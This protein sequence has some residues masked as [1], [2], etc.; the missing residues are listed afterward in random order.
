MPICAG[1]LGSVLVIF[2]ERRDASG[3]SSFS[4]QFVSADV[5]VENLV[6]QLGVLSANL[7]FHNDLHAGDIIP[8]ASWII[9]PSPPEE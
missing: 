9:Y 7:L 8:A 1:Q 3:I 5:S 2:P 6:D 4:V